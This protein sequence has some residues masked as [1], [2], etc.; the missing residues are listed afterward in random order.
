M[1]QAV[2][3][4]KK[5]KSSQSAARGA[6]GHVANARPAKQSATNMIWTLLEQVLLEGGEMANIDEKIKVL[7]AATSKWKAGKLELNTEQLAQCSEGL[8]SIQPNLLV[9]QK[10]H[11]SLLAQY[12]LQLAKNRNLNA[13]L[14]MVEARLDRSENMREELGRL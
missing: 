4:D 10:E 8:T 13:H 7:S 5:E 6:Q 2:C 14:D 3:T 12:Q 9:I 1:R 11:S